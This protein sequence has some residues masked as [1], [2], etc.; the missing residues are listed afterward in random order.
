ME[1]TKKEKGFTDLPSSPM[2]L[3]QPKFFRT[4]DVRLL[5][6][7]LVS[8][9]GAGTAHADRMRRPSAISF[10]RAVDG[11]PLMLSAV[12]HGRR[13]VSVN[14]LGYLDCIDLKT[15]SK[16][17]RSPM[18]E[19]TDNAEALLMPDDQTVIVWPYYSDKLHFLMRLLVNTVNPHCRE[20]S[21]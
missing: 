15:R 11:Q 10:T 12:D 6:L 13:L 17:A 9:L 16:V 5:C 2:T 8:W 21:W 18:F 20:E 7:A 4:R 14:A 19:G 3:A 1:K